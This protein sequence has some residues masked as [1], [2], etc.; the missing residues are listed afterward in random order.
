ML[1]CSFIDRLVCFGPFETFA[2]LR[3][4]PMRYFIYFTRVVYVIMNNNKT[5]SYFDIR[6]SSWDKILEEKKDLYSICN[7]RFLKY[8]WFLPG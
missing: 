3:L 1:R 4:F 2:N 5:N 8:L 6:T 7:L